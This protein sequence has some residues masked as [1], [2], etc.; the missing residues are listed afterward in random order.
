MSETLS[1]KPPRVAI[2]GAGAI[3]LYLAV[4]LR[5]AGLE[6]TLITRPGRTLSLPLQLDEGEASLRCDVLDQRPSDRPQAHDFVFVTLKAQDLPQALPE[7]LPWAGDEGSLVIAQ[8]GLPWWFLDRLETGTIL[9]ASDPGGQLL[10]QVE[11]RRVI[12]CVINKSVD[13]LTDNHL[14]AFAV[15]GDRFVFGRPHGT[16][17]AAVSRLVATLQF[18]GLP[19]EGVDDIVA[20]LWDK[21]LG[22]VVLNPLSAITGLDLATL[23]GEPEHYRTIVEG[24]NEARAVAHAWNLPAGRPAEER[25]T[26]TLRVAASGT[27][28]T[29]MLQDRQAGKSP[30]LDPIVGA[31]R[32]LAQHRQ[33]DTPT[34]DKLYLDARRIFDRI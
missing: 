7:I 33:I 30:E 21:L 11:L 14:L 27:F 8:N 12:A 34:L 19:A 23:L 32:E 31:V 2:F 29:S 6:T 25:L 28:R 24:I 18:A 16:A 22:N 17:D 15:D 3:G 26:R 10:R 1:F 5:A 13:R 9:R 4:R 20:P